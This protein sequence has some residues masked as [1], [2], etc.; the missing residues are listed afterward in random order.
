MLFRLEDLIFDGVI[1]PARLGA[2]QALA[3]R[4]VL[5][6]FCR[7]YQFMPDRAYAVKGYFLFFARLCTFMTIVYDYK[8]LST[9]AQRASS[10]VKVLPPVFL[11]LPIM[12]IGILRRSAAL[13]FWLFG[14]PAFLVT[15][16]VMP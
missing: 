9:S 11:G 3:V 6:H 16:W 14:P 1:E 12:S 8:H 7:M 15:R 13:S 5:T 4:L 2:G 10:E